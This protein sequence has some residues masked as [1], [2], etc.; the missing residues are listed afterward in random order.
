VWRKILQKYFIHFCLTQI[1]RCLTL[2]IYFYFKLDQNKRKTD[3][4]FGGMSRSSFA[5]FHLTGLKA[6]SGKLMQ[7]SVDRLFENDNEVFMSNTFNEFQVN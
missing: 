6:S 5:S 7:S 1:A 2:R 3:E 4:A